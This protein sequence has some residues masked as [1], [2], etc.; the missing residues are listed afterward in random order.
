MARSGASA[1]AGEYWAAVE[2]SEKRQLW[3]IED[4]EGKCLA[5]AASTHGTATSK[6]AAVELAKQMILD[7]RMPSPQ[8]ART[9]TEERR[10]LAREKR[11]NQPSVIRRRAKQEARD[12][13]MRANWEA[14]RRD[15]QEP[16]IWVLI[17]E[18]LDLADPDIW[19]NNVVA[20]MRPRLAIYFQAV[21]AELEYKQLV[22]WPTDVEARLADARRILALLQKT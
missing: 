15:R 7:G 18:L 16:P 17:S 1:I 2:W 13:A 10:R 3:C 19:K 22:G 4:A 21:V 6:A 20:S 14:E 5:H 9:V 11:D 12:L 8:D